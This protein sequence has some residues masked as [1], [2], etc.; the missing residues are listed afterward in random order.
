MIDLGMKY[1]VALIIIIYFP[2]HLFEESVGN[3]PNWMKEHKWTPEKLFCFQKSSKK[4][5]N[6]RSKRLDW[7]V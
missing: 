5:L 6:K 3:F 7:K 2:F 4:F 1:Y